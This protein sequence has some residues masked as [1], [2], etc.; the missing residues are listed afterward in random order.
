MVDAAFET[1]ATIGGFFLLLY[2]SQEELN[3]VLIIVT[4]RY[5]S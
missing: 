1:T 5:Y 3:V 4:G 2:L